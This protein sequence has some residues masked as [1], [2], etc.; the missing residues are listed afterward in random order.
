MIFFVFPEHG[1]WG[2]WSSWEECS[3]S[4]NGGTKSRVRQCDDPAPRHGGKECEGVDN[5]AEKCNEQEC[6]GM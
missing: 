4:S 2:S 5:E 6:P 1:N 3:Q